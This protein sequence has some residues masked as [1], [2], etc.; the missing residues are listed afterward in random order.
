M[1]SHF[2]PW[3]FSELNETYIGTNHGRL[4]FFNSN[5]KML[6]WYLILLYRS[7]KIDDVSSTFEKLTMTLIEYLS[8][9]SF[10]RGAIGVVD[11]TGT[12][13]ET[14]IFSEQASRLSPP[15]LAFLEENPQVSSTTNSSAEIYPPEPL[16]R[17]FRAMQRI[18]NILA[19]F[20]K[21]YLLVLEVLI[22]PRRYSLSNFDSYAG[23][24]L[25]VMP[26][27][28]AMLHAHDPWTLWELTLKITFYLVLSEYGISRKRYHGFTHSI[29]KCA[30]AFLKPTRQPFRE[31]GE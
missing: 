1:R 24:L 18:L 4:S 31:T 14:M 26:D 10:G 15:T 29:G 3:D 22:L 7:R 25:R 12:C 27:G 28:L 19:V 23:G 6:N 9:S 16:R 21:V 5:C 11:D 30:N 8:Q 13:Q 17:S 20:A 2:S